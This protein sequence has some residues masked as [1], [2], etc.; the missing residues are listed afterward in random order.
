MPPASSPQR[1]KLGQSALE[2]APIAFGGNVFGWTSDEVTSFRT[3]DAFVDA[4]FNLIDTADAY[5]RWVPGH[6]AVSRNNHRSLAGSARTAMRSRVVIATKVGLEMGPGE[7]GLSRNYILRAVDRS[8]ARLRRITST[9][10]RLIGMTPIRRWR[11]QPKSSTASFAP[12]KSGPSAR[13]ISLRSVCRTH[14]RRAA[15]S[16]WRVTNPCSRTTTCCTARNSK[17]N[18]RLFARRKAW[19]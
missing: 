1:R 5:S 6:A 13:R 3:L 15:G 18:S 4:G 8:L 19:V 17:R 12:E 11:K 7:S 2:V 16:E 9:S 10:T 14:S